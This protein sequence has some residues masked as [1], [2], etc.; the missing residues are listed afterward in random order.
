MA[1][2]TPGLPEPLR[3]ML[4]FIAVLALVYLA[5]CALLFFQQRSLIYL[6][7]PRTVVDGSTLLTLRVAGAEVLITTRPHPGE[8]ALLYFGGN[9]EDVSYGLPAIAAA[10]PDHAIYLMHYRGYGGS[11]GKPTEAALFSDAVALFDKVHAEHPSILVVGRSLGSGVAT[12]LASVRPASRLVL[13]TPYDS[14]AAVAAQHYPFFPVRWMMLDKFES[15]RYAE[16]VTAP[17]LILAA[18][19][20]EVI[21]A[22]RTQ[23]LLPHFRPGLATMTV[24]AGTSHNSISESADYFPALRGA[25]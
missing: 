19:S 14:L 24:I 21:P 5:M 9:A 1:E 7:Q 18:Q 25:R 4:A 23:A 16:R 2:S 20:D 22:A 3:K 8:R 17:T 15:W 12:Y 10:F 6:P 13:V 11:T